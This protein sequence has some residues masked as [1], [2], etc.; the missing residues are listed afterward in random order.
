MTSTIHFATIIKQQHQQHIN[1]IWHAM[2]AGFQ[3]TDP[4]LAAQW[5]AHQPAGYVSQQAGNPGLSMYCAKHH[6]SILVE[7]N[8]RTSLYF[9]STARDGH[10]EKQPLTTVLAPEA[11][12]PAIIQYLQSK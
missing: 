4:T 2:V 6:L 8:P 10:D 7:Y 5:G 11:I 9:I 12:A 1:R 3:A